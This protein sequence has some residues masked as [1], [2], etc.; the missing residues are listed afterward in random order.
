MRLHR[1]VLLFAWPFLACLAA[2]LSS[3]ATAGP[4]P[5]LSVGGRVFHRLVLDNGLHAVA[6]ADSSDS[7]TVFVVVAA[8]K[9]QESEAVTGVAHLTE[10]ALY[11]GTDS[12][13]ADEHENRVKGWGGESNAF[14]R[15]DYTLYYDHRFPKEHLAEVLRMEAD[16]M[17]GTIFRPAA[18]LHEQDRLRKEEERTWQP[19]DELTER[20][21]AA[22]YRAHNYKAGVLD[23]EHHTRA[24]ELGIEA[25]RRFYDTYYYPNHMAVVVVG[26]VEP[27]AALQAVRDAFAPLLPGPPVPR[28]PREPEVTEPRTE[29]LPSNLSRARV[30]FVWIVP[31]V[32]HPDRAKLDLLARLIGQRSASDSSPYI[33]RLDERIDPRLFR[34]ASTGDSASA[35]LEELMRDLRSRAPDRAEVDAVKQLL[36]DDFSGLP[37]RARPYF[38]LAGT[39]GVYEAL[40]HADLLAGYEAAI[41]TVGPEDLHRAVLTYLAPEQCVTVRF[42]PTTESLKPLPEDRKALAD[43]AQQAEA[44][45]DL[46]RAIAA[47][48]K[49]LEGKPSEMFTVIYLASR[50]QV[51]MAQHDFDGAIADFEEALG[52]IDYPA[53]RDLLEEAKA[54]R[55]GRPDFD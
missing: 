18:F 9:R 10:H 30:E 24:P 28:I 32:A 50:G 17:R 2:G 15:E 4:L 22:V 7:L 16:R 37:L 33:C 11:T 35:R 12:L 27:V 49:L 42:E 3:P 6:V 46:D 29:V 36:R 43:A 54:L 34:V 52:V 5:P 55:D 45:G 40:G 14:T 26:H 21:E 38:S 19:K 23:G 25:S 47:Y 51:R 13:A 1:N 41:D 20:L 39:F 48:T 44:S 8:G 31:G 53:V